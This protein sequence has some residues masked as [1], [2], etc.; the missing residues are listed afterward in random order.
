MHGNNVR[1]LHHMVNEPVNEP[2][3]LQGSLVNA[4]SNVSCQNLPM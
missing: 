2:E 4:A 1:R 3:E